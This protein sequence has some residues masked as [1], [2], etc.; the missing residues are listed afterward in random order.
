MRGGSN[1]EMQHFFCQ[2]E[3]HPVLNKSFLFPERLHC[4]YIYF[5]CS[6]LYNYYN[7]L[8]PC[9]L[10]AE[11]QLF[12]QLFVK[13]PRY[14]PSFTIDLSPTHSSYPPNT[15]SQKP[16]PG[17]SLILSFFWKTENRLLS[18]KSSIHPTCFLP[19]KIMRFEFWNHMSKLY[20]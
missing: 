19:L 2:T 1:S 16:K 12:G 14:L 8:K 4:C 17:Q 13:E 10:H 6:H 9:A 18:Q 11:F 5:H 20:F 7:Y 15:N 3:F